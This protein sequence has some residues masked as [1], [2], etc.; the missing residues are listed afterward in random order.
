MGRH[1]EAL[2]Q[3]MLA[4]ELEPVSLIIN[5]WVGLRHYLA[6]RY[7]M[8][9]QEYRNALNLDPNFAPAHWHLGWAYEQLGEFDAAIASAEK[10]VGI[11]ENPIYLASLGHAHAKAGNQP[12]ARRILGELDRLALTQHV[13]AYHVAVIH[14]ALGDMDNAFL[15]LGRAYAERAPWIAYM[16]VDPRLDPLRSDPRFA[17]LLKQARLD[18]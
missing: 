5:T 2:E 12:E 17:S 6:G 9:V 13:S 18:F 4:R 14:A 1:G 8:A 10:A 15:W 3:A 7:A 11:S 16:R